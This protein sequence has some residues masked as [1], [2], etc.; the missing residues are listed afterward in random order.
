MQQIQ[1]LF[2]GTFWIFKIFDIFKY[3]QYMVDGI[4]A[5]SSILAWKSH[6]Q[7]SLAGYSP[8]CRKQSDATER[9]SNRQI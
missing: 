7:R 4:C 8:W 5:H 6:G 3:F 1:V 9:L 2:F